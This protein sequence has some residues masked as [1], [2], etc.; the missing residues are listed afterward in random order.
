M[1]ISKDLHETQPGENREVEDDV[2]TQAETNEGVHDAGR[3]RPTDKIVV[4]TAGG[5]IEVE[6]PV[7]QAQQDPG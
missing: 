4:H 6:I 5:R 1:S 7:R 2:Q 3:E